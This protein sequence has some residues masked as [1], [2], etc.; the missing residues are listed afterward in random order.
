VGASAPDQRR[1]DRPVRDGKVLIPAG[2][3]ATTKE[4]IGGSCLIDRKD[5][6]EA[7]DRDDIANERLPAEGHDLRLQD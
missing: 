2:P 7:I 3:F 4:Q 6:D 5:L 1:D